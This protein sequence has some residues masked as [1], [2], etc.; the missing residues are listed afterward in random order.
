MVGCAVQA[1]RD[2]LKRDH[3]TRQACHG[4]VE[5][6]AHAQGFGALHSDEAHLAP[7]VIAAFELCDLSF[8]LKGIVFQSG[9]AI[10]EDPAESGADFEAFLSCGGHGPGLSRGAEI[11]FRA[12]SCLLEH[13]RYYG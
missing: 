13:C 1:G 11:F 12:A 4:A 7:D 8:I 5:E 3:G 2:E 10:F 9:N 6:E